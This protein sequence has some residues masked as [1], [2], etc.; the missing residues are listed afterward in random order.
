MTSTFRSSRRI[1]SVVERQYEL[2]RV[3]SISNRCLQQLCRP[4]RA[5]ITLQQPGGV[6]RAQPGIGGARL[7]EL[8]HRGASSAMTGTGHVG[9]TGHDVALDV[10]WQLPALGWTKV[11]VDGS[12]TWYIN[13]RIL[14][15]SLYV[16]VITRWQIVFLVS[17]I[18][19]ILMFMFL[20]T[21]WTIFK[22]YF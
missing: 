14:N 3:D 21:S 9:M 20:S 6:T 22:I 16:E 17:L 15:S 12:W 2:S 5:G 18:R 19:W 11:N 4:G 1:I 10:G 7:F 13:L 8:Q